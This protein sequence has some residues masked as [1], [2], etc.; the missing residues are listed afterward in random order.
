MQAVQLQAKSAG[1]G[2]GRRPHSVSRID[3]RR[4]RLTICCA[5]R[6]HTGAE[7]LFERLVCRSVSQMLRKGVVLMERSTARLSDD[8]PF[9]GEHM[10]QL[11]LVI[12]ALRRSLGGLNS[13]Q[14]EALAGTLE[15]LRDSVIAEGSLQVDAAVRARAP[16]PF[17]DPRSAPSKE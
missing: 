8:L 7:T 12:K 2:F 17:E 13:N 9:S 6:P 4:S 3:V 10:A 1:V 14:V 5:P 16:I 15:R 11:Q